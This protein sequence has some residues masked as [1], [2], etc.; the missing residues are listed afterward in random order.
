MLLVYKDVNVCW[1]QQP[2]TY[3]IT[4]FNTTIY[5]G[6]NII[7]N[8]SSSYTV[9]NKQIQDTT[10]LPLKFKNDWEDDNSFEIDVELVE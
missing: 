1:L 5:L 4:L 2:V 10:S 8:K 6:D 3:V 7:G 9:Q